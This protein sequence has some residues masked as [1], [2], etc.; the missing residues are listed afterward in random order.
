MPPASSSGTIARLQG[1]IKA[2]SAPMSLGSLGLGKTTSRTSTNHASSEKR[3]NDASGRPG[4]S[5]D[6][7]GKE[8]AFDRMLMSDPRQSG[9]K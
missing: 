5:Y 2:P 7:Q 1:A 6:P 8:A 4:L 3:R 9:S